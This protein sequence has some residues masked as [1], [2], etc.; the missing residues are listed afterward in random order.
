MGGD[1]FS[2]WESNLRFTLIR[3]HLHTLS[4]PVGTW[5][6]KTVKNWA[7]VDIPHGIN[8]FQTVCPFCATPLDGAPGYIELIFQDNLD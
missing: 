8:G 5:L 6:Q 2:L 7:N 1:V 4:I 3:V